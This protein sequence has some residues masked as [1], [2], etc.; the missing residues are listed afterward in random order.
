M[1]KRMEGWRGHGRLRGAVCWALLCRLTT[2]TAV[3]SKRLGLDPEIHNLTAGCMYA[4]TSWAVESEV[5]RPALV[6]AHYGE[7]M[8]S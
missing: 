1:G 8:S 2:W 5:E 4:A 7:S 3:A 6:E